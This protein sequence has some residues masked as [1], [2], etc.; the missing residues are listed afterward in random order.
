MADFISGMNQGLSTAR[1]MIY[2]DQQAKDETSL[3]SSRAQEQ[4]LALHE[5]QQSYAAKMAIYSSEK[6]FARENNNID[7]N[8]FSGI[9]QMYTSL[10]NS[11]NIR[12]NPEAMVQLLDMK[13]KNKIQMQQAE[14]ANKDIEIAQTQ[15]VHDAANLALQNPEDTLGWSAALE[16]AKTPELKQKVQDG[17]SFFTS[18]KYLSLDEDKKALEQRKFLGHFLAGNQVATAA[19]G[20]ATTIINTSKAADE[21][22]NKKSLIRDRTIKEQQGQQRIDIEKTKAQQSAEKH[23]S[24]V[25]KNIDTLKKQY[26]DSIEKIDAQQ[27]KI[28]TDNGLGSIEDIKSEW[29]GMVQ[30]SAA[31]PAVK[32]QYATLEKAKLLRK[33]NLAEGLKQYNKESVAADKAIVD[34]KSE[35]KTKDTPINV[36]TVDEVKK[37]SKGTFYKDPNGITYQKN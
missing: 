23:A 30:R 17:Q 28:R 15:E 2:G 7:I 24:D 27:A 12:S 34:S 9:D 20:L 14:K 25:R 33:A 11:P 36:T 32:A 16:R 3:L 1:N 29:F 6:D 35:G 8:S 18:P 13:N 31:S 26:A 4:K 5:H 10:G 37:L 19:N 22:E 21:H